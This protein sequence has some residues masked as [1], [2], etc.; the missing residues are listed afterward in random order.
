MVCHRSV[1]TDRTAVLD[2]RSCKS[3][4]AIG[5]PSSCCAPVHF[6]ALRALF[7]CLRIPSTTY[8]RRECSLKLG[9]AYVE[10]LADLLRI[11]WTGQKRN[12]GVR[13]F[14]SLKQPRFRKTDDRSAARCLTKKTYPLT[15]HNAVRS[16]RPFNRGPCVTVVRFCA[17]H[18]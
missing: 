9:F 17:P 16:S 5:F 18:S 8:A 10:S 14:V 15:R 11:Q 4:H 2:R 7:L 12:Y 1:P 3:L 6:F 13:G